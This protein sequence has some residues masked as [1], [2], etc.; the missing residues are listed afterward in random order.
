MTYVE[1]PVIKVAM[2]MLHQ[3]MYMLTSCFIVDL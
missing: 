2:L 1:L 3:C